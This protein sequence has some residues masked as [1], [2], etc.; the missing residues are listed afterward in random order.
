MFVIHFKTVYY[1]KGEIEVY[2]DFI[3]YR[4]V[5]TVHYSFTMLFILILTIIAS[6]DMLLFRMHVTK[7]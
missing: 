4:N 5:I 3:I 7:A 2:N 6:V 1:N